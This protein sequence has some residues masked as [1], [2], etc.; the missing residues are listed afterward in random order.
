MLRGRAVSQ[1]FL[2]QVGFF[3]WF[4]GSSWPHSV[5]C[6]DNNDFRRILGTVFVIFPNKKEF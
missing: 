3:L 2:I 4:Y 6:Q 5:F 1:I